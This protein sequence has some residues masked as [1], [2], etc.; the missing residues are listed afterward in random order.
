L[1]AKVADEEVWAKAHGGKSRLEMYN[2]LFDEIIME[3]KKFSHI[4]QKIKEVYL[5]EIQSQPLVELEELRE[6]HE[7]LYIDYADLKQRYLQLEKDYQILSNAMDFRDRQISQLQEMIAQKEKDA[8][9]VLYD[10]IKQDP[11]WKL[12]KELERTMNKLRTD[13]EERSPANI[14]G[15]S[16]ETARETERLKQRINELELEVRQTKA[17]ER[18]LYNKYLVLKL[19]APAYVIKPEDS[20]SGSFQRLQDVGNAEVKTGETNSPDQIGKANAF[21]AVAKFRAKSVGVVKNLS[22][23][24]N[25]SDS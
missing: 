20:D 5:F 1:E 10:Q 18:D 4:L 14:P 19:H 13:L 6:S 16:T 7:L 3:D 22:T 21:M 15:Y 17:R 23:R 9:S 12:P 8:E 25:D 11:V 24:K 2:T